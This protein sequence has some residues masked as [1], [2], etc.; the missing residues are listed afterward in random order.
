MDEGGLR[1]VPTAEDVHTP[2]FQ[3][4]FFPFRQHQFTARH[5][6]GVRDAEVS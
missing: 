2:R 6:A 4:R 5:W 1:S 3:A